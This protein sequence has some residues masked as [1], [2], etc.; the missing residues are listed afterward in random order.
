MTSRAKLGAAIGLI[1][2]ASL[3]FASLLLWRMTALL[4]EG[5]TETAYPY[6]RPIER[7]AALGII[8]IIGYAMMRRS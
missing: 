3:V 1:G 6:E 8:S 4:H 7:M 5:A 2:I